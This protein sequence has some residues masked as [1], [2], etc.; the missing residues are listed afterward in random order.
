MAKEEST[1]DGSSVQGTD[2]EATPALWQAMAKHEGNPYRNPFGASE[3]A[4]VARD[5]TSG[6]VWQYM[7]DGCFRHRCHPGTGTRIYVRV[8]GGECGACEFGPDGLRMRE[9]GGA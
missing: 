2:S 7:G 1:R 8:Q 3:R 5:G 6:E 4:C 9:G